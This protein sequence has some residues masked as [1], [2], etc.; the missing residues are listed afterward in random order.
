KELKE[1]ENQGS[2]FLVFLIIYLITLLGNTFTLTMVRVNP[3][4]HTPMYYFLS[5]LSF[6]DIFYS[7]TTIL[8][9]LEKKTNLYERCLSQILFLVTCAGA[10]ADAV[11]LAASEGLRIF[12]EWDLTVWA[13]EFCETHS[14]DTL[15][16]PNQV[17]HFLC[18]IPLLLKFS[19]SDTSLSGS[20]FHMAS[21]TTG[22]SSCLFTAVSY[23][24]IISDILSIPS[25]QGRSKAFSTC[26]SHLPVFGTA[27]LN[28]NRPSISYILDILVS[29]PCC[30]VAPMFNPVIYSLRKKEIKGALRKWMEKIHVQLNMQHEE[31]SSKIQGHGYQN[32]WRK[33]PGAL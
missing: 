8:V 7:S 3:A 25:A 10:G 1:M 28:Y 32:K 5:T 16:G 26:A 21:T 14:A 17:S 23:M 33:F 4:L 29:V 12:V 24:L 9:M 11:L 31:S 15:C 13:R 19:C 6:L 2:F 27:N 30:V 18:D 20:V 22:L